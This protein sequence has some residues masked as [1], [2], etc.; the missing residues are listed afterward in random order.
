IYPFQAYGWDTL[1]KQEDVIFKNATVWTNEKDGIL[2]NTDVWIRN[3]KIYQV[4]KNLSGAAK[5]IDATGKHLTSGVIDEHS[6]IA[7]SQGVNEGTQSVTSEVRIGD[8]LNSDDINIY[9][10]L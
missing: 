3:G 5:T 4:G 7:I 8:V 6:H 2:S 9:R 10:Q 1:P